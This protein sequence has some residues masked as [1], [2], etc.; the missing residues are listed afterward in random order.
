MVLRTESFQEGKNKAED[1]VGLKRTLLYHQQKKSR[2]GRSESH[3]KF[4]LSNKRKGGSRD[5]NDHPW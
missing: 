5:D 4:F 3:G 2:Q 1:H